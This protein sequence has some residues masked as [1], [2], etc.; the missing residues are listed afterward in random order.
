MLTNGISQP[1]IEKYTLGGFRISGNKDGVS[2][3]VLPTKHHSLVKFRFCQTKKKRARI[4]Y[5]LTNGISQ[6]IIEKYTLGGSRTSGNKDG[7]SGNVLLT[8]HHS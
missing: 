3:N 2:E 1:I 6:P 7:F 8:K 4:T 5:K